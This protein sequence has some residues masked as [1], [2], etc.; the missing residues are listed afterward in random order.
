MPRPRV[1]VVTEDTATAELIRGTLTTE[2]CDVDTVS[3]SGPRKRPR[4]ASRSIFAFCVRWS[5]G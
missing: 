1:L 3:S 2:R 4:W 5:T